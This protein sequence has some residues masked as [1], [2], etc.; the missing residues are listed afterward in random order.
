MG[1][2]IYLPG[3]YICEAEGLIK[4]HGTELS[5]NK[6]LSTYFG[7]VKQINKL[8]TVVPVSPCRY[9]PEVGDVVIGRVTQI[10]NKKWRVE[11][12]SKNDTVLSLSAISL[13]GVAQRRKSEEDEI[14]MSRFFDVDDLLVCEVQKVNKS[15]SAALHTRNDKYGKLSNG[16]FV[17]VPHILLCPLKARFLKFDGIEIIAGCNGYLWIQASEDSAES[18]RRVSFVCKK[19]RELS[20]Q[21]MRIN[22]ESILDE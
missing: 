20:F 7:H 1:N 13:P 6:I 2:K 12:N 15:G 21:G 10:F 18:Y 11:T 19:I 9:V 22:L 5:S 16:V 8:I 17:A 3:D 4:G 14:N